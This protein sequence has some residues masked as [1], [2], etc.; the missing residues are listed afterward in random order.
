MALEAGCLEDHFPLK[1]T[2]AM[3][4]GEG[5]EAHG[6]VV[7]SDRGG[8]NPKKISVWRGCWMCEAEAHDVIPGK[9]WPLLI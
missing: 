4:V 5:M 2:R 8:Q 6:F 9:A 3:L 7:K 1:R